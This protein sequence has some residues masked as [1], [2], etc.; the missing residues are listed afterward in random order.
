MT[1][2]KGRTLNAAPVK[3][4]AAGRWLKIL[5]AAG[6][7][8]ELLD[9][10]GHPCPKCGGTDRF[11]AM[12][13]VAERG[14]VLCRGCFPKGGGDGLA[15]VQWIRDIDFPAAVRFVADLLNISPTGQAHAGN[16]RRRIVATY[17]YRDAGGN[18]A[19]Q[20]VR[21]EPKDF[22]QRS[23]KPGGGWNWTTK[24]IEPLPYRLPELLAA[25]AS[26]PVVVC[27]GEKDADSLARFGII[28]TTNHGGAGKW[29]TTHAQHL[30]RRRV[31]II[32][33]ADEPGE[34]HAQAVAASL[35]G[36][37]ASVRIV[38]LPTGKDASDW[39][40]AGGTADELQRL[41]DAAPEWTPDAAAAG[42]DDGPK[43]DDHK[44]SPKSQSTML[45]ELARAA[46]LWHTP[47]QGDAYATIDA[48]GHLEHWPIRSRTFKRWLCRQYYLTHKRT[49][50]SQS[51]QDAL[52]VL[53]GEAIFAGETHDAAV[54]VAEH[55]G[56]LYLDLCDDKWR[57]VEI[58]AD[59][60]RL[61]KRCPVRFRRAK[62]MLPLP[63][64]QAGGAIDQLRR[65]VNV[66]DDDWP[67]VLGWLVAALRPMGPYPVLALHGE[68]GSAK[69]TVARVLRAIVD[70]NVAPVRCEPREPRDLAIA[71]NN[72]WVVATDNLSH[73]PGWLSDALCR[74][75]HRRR[76]RHPHTLRER[77]RNHLPRHAADDTDR[78]RR[79]GQ[80]V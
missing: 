10:R 16:G 43:K 66:A 22:R 49:P 71:A 13:D 33:D 30:A 57:S 19:Y 5:P 74:L 11:A 28:A 69:T 41:I 17:D 36:L 46:Q 8:A 61:M 59:G 63:V 78:H 64:P 26:R 29:T 3:A 25:D 51:V 62:A 6:I 38:S 4:A 48:G 37:A 20:A 18:L 27:E 50:G 75:S 40:Q 12:K 44:P 31:A 67:L 60:W 45:V 54:R 76:I 9:G 70:P 73:V 52:G 47:G 7:A 34:R 79:S 80:P 68:Q 55:D 39:L 42:V 58:D 65:F 1:S 14:A 35:R 53:E 24:G 32:P 21:Y 72:G 23:P 56:R 15:A 2:S 77:R